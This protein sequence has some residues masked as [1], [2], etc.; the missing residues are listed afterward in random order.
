M[1]AFAVEECGS[2]RAPIIWA[3]TRNAR[4]MPVNAEPVAKGGN[5]ALAAGPNGTPIATVL[6]V[7]QQFGRKALYTSH[8]TDCPN[9]DRHRR[10]RSRSGP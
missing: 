8:F 1:S 3:M 4:S 5:I 10:P 7:A 2:C 9:A 6:S